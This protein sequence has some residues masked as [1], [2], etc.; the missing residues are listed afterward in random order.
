MLPQGDSAFP[1]INGF[2]IRALSYI[3]NLDKKTITFHSDGWH[4]PSAWQ[5]TFFCCCYASY[6]TPIICA[7]NSMTS[8]ILQVS[9]GRG[10]LI[11]TLILLPIIE[12][13]STLPLIVKYCY[14]AS[15]IPEFCAR[16]ARFFLF[17]PAC[18]GIHYWASERCLCIAS[19]PSTPTILTEL[20]ENIL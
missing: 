6:I 13:I 9:E 18:S 15:G 14:L 8:I 10:T 1:L 12:F 5:H 4:Q 19:T 3:W 7:Q 17:I 11:A 16:D 2:W 20:K